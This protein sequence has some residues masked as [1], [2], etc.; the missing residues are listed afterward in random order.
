MTGDNTPNAWGYMAAMVIAVGVILASR[1]K[2][3]K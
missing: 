2:K 1:K 3:S